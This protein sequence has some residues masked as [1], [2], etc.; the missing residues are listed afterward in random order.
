MWSLLFARISVLYSQEITAVQNGFYISLSIL[1]YTLKKY[2][3]GHK[4]GK[5]Q[6]LQLLFNLVASYS[7]QLEF[8]VSFRGWVFFL[9]AVTAVLDTYTCPAHF[10]SPS[11]IISSLKGRLLQPIKSCCSL[12][13]FAR[14][15]HQQKWCVRWIVLKVSYRLKEDWYSLRF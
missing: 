5:L 13:F 3:V 9:K 8:W 14:L 6:S 4:K 7:S 15:L 11:T 1:I 10:Q 2:A 12:L